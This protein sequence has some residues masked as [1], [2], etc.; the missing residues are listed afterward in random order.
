M[1]IAVYNK[2]EEGQGVPYAEGVDSFLDNISIGRTSTVYIKTVC[3]CIICT[4]NRRSR[5]P[6]PRLGKTIELLLIG[7]DPGQSYLHFPVPGTR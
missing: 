1:A 4:T 5:V 6:P 3:E 7:Q 2:A